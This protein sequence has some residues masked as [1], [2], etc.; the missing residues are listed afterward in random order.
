[1]VKVFGKGGILF[2]LGCVLA[3]NRWKRA[4]VLACLAMLLVSPI[5]GP[6]KLI[7]GR[8][9][10]DRTDRGS[11]PSG[12]AAAVTAFL[13]PIA[14]IFP[15]TKPIAI[16][17]VAAIG[18][19]RVVLRKHFP[20]DVLGGIAIGVFVSAVVLSLNIPLRPRIRRFLRRSWLAAGL[21]LL[22]PVYL[23]LGGS[24]DMKRFLVIFGPAVALLVIAPFVRS[25]MRTLGRVQTRLLKGQ[26][27]ILWLLGV[28][29][30]IGAIVLMVGPWL[31]P[32]FR[33]NLP[34][35]EPEE[36]GLI[37]PITALGWTLFIMA[38][39]ALR[40]HAARRYHSS[41]G[42]LVAGMVGVI[43]IITVL[44]LPIVERLKVSKPLADAIRQRT[45]AEFSV[46]EMDVGEPNLIFYLGQ[47]QMKVN[48]GDQH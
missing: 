46:P 26:E 39:L 23:L 24:G 15:A 25:W 5:I 45:V 44:V 19:Q 11:F 21:G 12:D 7:F 6:S 41:V 37:W 13:V 27:R 2:L 10:P 8:E 28:T 38:L 47:K 36:R 48:K 33:L 40:E 30:F 35:F 3:I 31:L 4:A 42:I 43:F 9:R 17:S 16:A 22:V 32:L 20:S 18:I 34:F 29:G 14:T 1:M